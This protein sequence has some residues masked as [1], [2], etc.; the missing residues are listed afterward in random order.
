MTK[1]KQA[2]YGQL[3]QRLDEVVAALES[4]TVTID[5]AM[6]LYEEGTKLVGELERYLKNAENRITKLKRA[7]EG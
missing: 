2:D 1:S 7:S 3:N 4:P 6:R 5:E